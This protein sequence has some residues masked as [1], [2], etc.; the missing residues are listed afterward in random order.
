[1]AKNNNT[2]LTGNVVLLLVA[3]VLGV[4]IGLMFAQSMKLGH[5]KNETSLQ[6]KMGEV[7]E[8]VEE[9][10]VDPLD[11]DSISE[12]LIAV[13]LNELD[14]HSTYLS[15]KAT[16]KAD[17][18]LRGSFE[19][20][21]IVLHRE[22]DTTYVGQVLKDGPSWGLGIQPGDMIVAID[23]D[24]VCG[25]GI[26][27]DSV[28]ARLRG[29]RGSRVVVDMLRV[30]NGPN[31]E[32]RAPQ[33]LQ[34]SIR[35]GVVPHHTVL[36]HSMLNDTTGYIMVNSFASTTYDEFRS[37]LIDLKRNRLRHLIIDLRGNG[38]GTLNSAIGMCSE[39]LPAGSLIVYTKGEHSRRRNVY[40]PG[41][42]LFASGRITVMVDE[43]SASASEVVSG[44]LQDNDRALIVG[45]RTFGKGLVQTD[46]ELQDGSSLLLT[47]ARYY[48]PSGR[49]IQRPYTDGTRE[50][51]RAYYNQLIEETY[52]DSASIHIND[53]TPYYTVNGRVV[54]GGGGIIP[55]VV[56][57]IRKDSSFVYYNK[58]AAGGRFARV[59]FGYVKQHSEELTARYTDATKF[60]KEFKVSNELLES[61]V[62]QG[63]AQG[64]ARDAASIKK[65]RALMEVMLKSYIGQFLYGDEGFYSTYLTHDEDLTE[66]VK[67][68]AM[69]LAKSSKT[70]K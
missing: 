37:A 6:G 66:A 55:D 46:Y 16:I 40:S 59:A 29:P 27:S 28:V 57:P 24:T 51:Y 56:Q 13:M 54:Y 11:I 35:R 68:P 30:C 15:A 42:G 22:G 70:K 65:Q 48:T 12:R 23:G 10:Y 31:G 2:K 17:E 18:M 43:N 53:S 63:E 49:C 67:L 14:P 25:K 62:Q 50:Y 45:R 61:L 44:A 9:Q 19:G 60:K 39:L 26:A 4:L 69:K 8:L 47:T 64:I 7:M 5:G 41:G 58:L 33:T 52:A 20:I 38:G 1:M 3:M 32:K 36:Y 21:G 34:F